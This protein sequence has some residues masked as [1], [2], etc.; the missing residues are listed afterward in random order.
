MEL[1]GSVAN[2]AKAKAELVQ[3][4]PNDGIAVLNQDD[5][6]VRSMAAQA[7]CRVVSYGLNEKADVWAEN[8]HYSAQ[9][10]R[11]VSCY[12]DERQVMEIPAVGVH[13]VY[14]SRR[15]CDSEAAGLSLADIAAA[16]QQYE[17]SGMRFEFEQT[18]RYLLV[19]DAYNASPLSMRAAIDTVAAIA[20]D[21][22]WLF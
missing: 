4:L 1:L 15:C 8:V 21:G 13:N 22:L 18:P 11:Y 17:P 10:I 5:A 16:L 20:R 14:N 19:N 6:L 9:G 7:P 2:I 3:A 12:K